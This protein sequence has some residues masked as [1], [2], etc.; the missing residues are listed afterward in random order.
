MMKT[1][2]TILWTNQLAL[3]VTTGALCVCARSQ[4]I[5]LSVAPAVHVRWSTMTNK[6]YQVEVSTNVS[7]DWIPT[8][9]LIE[10]TGAGVGAY[11]DAIG[12]EQF[13]KVQQTSACGMNWLEGVWQGETYQSS[14]NSVPFTARLS[15]ANSSRTF[16][17]IYSN[18]LFSCSAD[19]V[20]LSYSDAQARF[21]TRILSGPC[22]NGTVIVTRVNTTNV[23]Y[24]WYH[25][26]G[27][28]VASSFAVLTK[29]P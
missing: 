19:L 13:F 24:D 28:T 17:A 12:P 8:G 2:Q 10:G 3:T 23:L 22:L 25:S 21:D 18:N 4:D 1:R 16:G 27:P 26:A 14:S 9:Q 20:L 5:T 11:F 7:G 15:I 6:A 29:R